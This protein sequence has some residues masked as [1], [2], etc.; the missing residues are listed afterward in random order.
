MDAKHGWYSKKMAVQIGHSYIYKS[1]TG[2]PIA[3]TYVTDNICRKAVSFDDLIYVGL[4]TQFMRQ[5]HEYVYRDAQ[6]INY[7]KDYWEKKSSLED[8]LK[9]IRYS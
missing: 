2:E 5:E 6:N 7:E 1:I 3:V 8:F 4:I 9:T